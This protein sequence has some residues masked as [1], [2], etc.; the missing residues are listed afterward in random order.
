MYGTFKRR[1]VTLIT[2]SFLAAM[3]CLLGCDYGG[4]RKK[5]DT[6]AVVSESE[7]GK[8]VAE[9]AE[10]VLVFGFDLRST[11]QEDAR[12]YLPFLNYLERATG[13]RFKLRFT[14]RGA[15]IADDLGTGVVQFAAIGA[16]SYLKAREKYSVV[17]LVRGLN[18]LGKAEYQSLLVVAPDSAIREVGDLRGKRLA[19]GDL[20]STQGHLIPRIILSEHG[21]ALEDLASYEYTGS[22]HNCAN[23]VIEGR[24]D[25]CGMQDTMG[26]SFET[27]GLVRIIKTSRYYPSSGI[28]ANG[29]VSPEVLERVRRAL[30]DFK[31]RGRDAGGLYH[32]ELTEMPNG[33]AP[34]N[35]ADYAELY[36]WGQKLGG[37]FEDRDEP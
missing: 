18:T 19:L 32:W 26:R 13:F 37:F 30:I 1:A 6:G 34:A 2:F 28:A 27:Q 21:I 23:S 11:P 36:E 9:K 5:V 29:D 15:S 33:F 25:A 31:P 35:E 7:L 8:P 14:P 20:N 4:E 3:N 10:G 16:G 22:H 12:Q 17:P 24:A